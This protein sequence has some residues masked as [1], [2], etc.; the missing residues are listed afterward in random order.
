MKYFISYG[1]QHFKMSLDRIR[2]EAENLKIFDKIITYTPADFSDDFKKHPLLKYKRGG[3]Y[4]VWKAYFVLKTLEEMGEDDILFYADSGCNL[5]PP[6]SWE[7]Y[8][9]FLR[10]K[11]I[12]CFKIVRRCGAYTKKNVLE[13][14]T[15]QLGPYW[16]HYYQIA[17]TTFFMRK[18]A[19]TLDFTKEWFSLFTEDMIL[20]STEPQHEGFIEHRHDQSILSGLLYKYEDHAEILTNDFESRRKGQAILASRLR[21][22]VSPTTKHKKSWGDFHI[23]RPVGI[24][25]RRCEQFYWHRRN[26]NYLKNG[27][28]QKDWR[29]V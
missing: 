2:K 7:K 9:K 14:F 16:R 22:D 26:T 13:Y 1:D 12:V 29:L 21:D 6:R 15:P 28:W 17:A 20:D 5:F 25:L 10:H 27:K 4:W 3:G 24:F 18:N 19:F 11:D 23:K 8:F